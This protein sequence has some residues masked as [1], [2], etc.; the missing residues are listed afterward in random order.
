[1]VDNDLSRDGFLCERDDCCGDPRIMSGPLLSSV[2][3][4]F[5]AAIG[6]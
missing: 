1:M 3:Q 6:N 4:C 5:N 2:N